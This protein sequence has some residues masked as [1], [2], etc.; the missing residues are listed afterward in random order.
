MINDNS[1]TNK[2]LKQSLGTTSKVL[3]MVEENAYC[4][5]IIQQIDS[6]IGTLKTARSLLLSQHLDHCV[7]HRLKVNKSQTIKELL[8]IYKLSN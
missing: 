1:K 4:I 5:D 7:E 8:D 6:S 3:N 2:L